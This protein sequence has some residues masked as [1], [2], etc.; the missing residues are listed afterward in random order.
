MVD[1]KFIDIEG[2]TRYHENLNE[3]INNK[4]NVAHNHDGVYAKI[5]DVESMIMEA[6]VAAINMEY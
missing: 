5:E 6:I 3:I 4:A 2:L 1:K